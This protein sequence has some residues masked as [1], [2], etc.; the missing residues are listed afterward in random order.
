MSCFN[1]PA[2][3]ERIVFALVHHLNAHWSQK[4]LPAFTQHT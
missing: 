2:S 4:R 3:I 1:N